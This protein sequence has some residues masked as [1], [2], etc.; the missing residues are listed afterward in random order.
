MKQN[1]FELE[2]L[3]RAGDSDAQYEI[4]REYLEDPSGSPA[5]QQQ[6]IKWLTN[7]AEDGNAEAQL[8]LGNCYH[9]GDGVIQ[10]SQMAFTLFKQASEQG[11]AAADLA[12]SL[13]Y[14]TGDGVPEDENL[15]FHHMKKAADRGI[16]EAQLGVAECYQNGAGTKQDLTKAFKYFKKAAEQGDARAQTRLGMCYQMGEGVAQNEKL[17]HKW[18]LTAAKNDDSLAQYLLGMSCLDDTIGRI[19]EKGAFEW[20]TKASEDDSDFGQLACY[21]LARCYLYGWGTKSD[22]A[23]ALELYPENVPELGKNDDLLENLHYYA[24]EHNIHN[25]KELEEILDKQPTIFCCDKNLFVY[26]QSLIPEYRQMIATGANK[27]PHTNI[28][29]DLDTTTCYNEKQLENI[30]D[31]VKFVLT[32]NTKEQ[33]QN[34]LQDLPN[35]ERTECALILTEAITAILQ[36]D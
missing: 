18:F 4:A 32:H 30:A 11:L 21:G 5:N 33:L 36:E 6:A 34:L 26:L 25:N 17:A 1:L 10:D 16:P 15:A 28:D 13:C 23:H 3:A 31:E 20:W 24:K 9:E 7:A 35:R 27:L 14:A 2:L 19:D 22:M 8:L 29:V 12:L